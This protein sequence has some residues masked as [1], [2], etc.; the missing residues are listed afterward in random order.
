MTT[1]LS[2]SGWYGST[3]KQFTPVEVFGVGQSDQFRTEAGRQ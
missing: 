2:G 1:T 3:Q